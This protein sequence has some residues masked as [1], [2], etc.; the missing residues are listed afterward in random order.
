MRRNHGYDVDVVGARCIAQIVDGICIFAAL[1]AVVVLG[2]G[3]AS[4]A[5]GLSPLLVLVVFLLPIGYNAGLETYWDGQTVGKKLMNVKVLAENGSE[6]GPG[7][8]IVRN[9]PAV[10]SFGIFSVL[11]AFV[12]MAMTDR[13]QRLFDILAGTVVVKDSTVRTGSPDGYRA[14]RGTGG[15]TADGRRR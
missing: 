14:G 15:T 12:S 1:I 3:L 6:A 7:K 11:V 8:A 10:F 13:K 5:G 9:L 2:G 4:E